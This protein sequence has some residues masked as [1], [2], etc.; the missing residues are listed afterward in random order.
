MKYWTLA[1]THY[2]DVE[3]YEG[4]DSTT[5]NI[6][7]EDRRFDPIWA[8]MDC[9]MGAWKSRIC[10]V[11]TNPRM[12][13]PMLQTTKIKAIVEQFEVEDDGGSSSLYI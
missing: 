3:T 8:H 12:R 5:G 4:W 9:I 6:H 11:T 1:S 10:E 2:V 13:I 7:H